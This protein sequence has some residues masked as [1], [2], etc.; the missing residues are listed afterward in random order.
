MAA[1][2][3]GALEAI[4]GIMEYC[5]NNK[6]LCLHQLWGTE[7]VERWFFTNSDQ[8]S[9]QHRAQQQ[10]AK[11]AKLLRHE[12]TCADRVWIQ[13]LICQVWPRP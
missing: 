5:I 12:G 1:L 3:Q 6:D 13:G 10:V 9:M 7:G 2:V 11:S 4:M 8:S